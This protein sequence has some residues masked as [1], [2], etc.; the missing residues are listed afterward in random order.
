MTSITINGNMCAMVGVA[1]SECNINVYYAVAEWL[2][3][4]LRIIR[5]L[6]RGGQVQ[7]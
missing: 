5:A 6:T 3:R 7:T 2:R 1:L 4:S